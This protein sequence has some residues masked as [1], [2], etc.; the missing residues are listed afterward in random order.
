[1]EK[2]YI[3]ILKGF[4]GVGNKTYIEFIPA[5]SVLDV[6]PPYIKGR[7]TQSWKNIKNVDLTNKEQCECCVSCNGLIPPF[8]LLPI[9]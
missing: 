8:L 2:S 4:N 1:M 6:K 5:E 7:L 3:R 9:N